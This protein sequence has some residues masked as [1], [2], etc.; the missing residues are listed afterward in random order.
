L[1][2]YTRFISLTS[3]SS[4]YGLTRFI[5]KKFYVWSQ[6]SLISQMS[7]SFT[8]LERFQS[9]LHSLLTSSTFLG[10]SLPIRCRHIKKF[11]LFF[12]LWF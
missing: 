5:D 8:S 11:S 7:Q 10:S 1:K 3:L 9:L 2:R 6:S 12:L 4:K